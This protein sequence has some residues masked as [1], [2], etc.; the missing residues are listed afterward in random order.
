[1]EAD[2]LERRRRQARPKQLLTSKVIAMNYIR[3]HLA[4][5]LSAVLGTTKGILVPEELLR[6][7]LAAFGTG[8]FVSLALSVIATISTSVNVIF[9]NPIV[10]GAVTLVLTLLA[11]LLRRLQHDNPAPNTPVKPVMPVA[12]VVPAATATSP[13]NAA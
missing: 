13:E 7:V 2:A 10:G 12:P 11:D 6:S 9:P 3:T 8:S 4:A 5:F 1:M